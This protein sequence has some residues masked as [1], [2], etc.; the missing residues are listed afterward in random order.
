MNANDFIRLVSKKADITITDTELFMNALVE[1]VN[2]CVKNKESFTILNFGTLD[3]SER[4]SWSVKSRMF[5]DKTFPKVQTMFF[6]LSVN[7]KKLFKDSNKT[8]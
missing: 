6:R 4:K 2:E 8:E 7:L 5:G 1:A 3:F